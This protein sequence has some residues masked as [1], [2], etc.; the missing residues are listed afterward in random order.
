MSTSVAARPAGSTAVAPSAT[1]TVEDALPSL[2]TAVLA[3]LAPR[4]A[5]RALS[6]DDFR[7]FL[8]FASDV[9]KELALGAEERRALIDAAARVYVSKIAASEIEEALSTSLHFQVAPASRRAALFRLMP[10]KR[11]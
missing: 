11:P 7:E 8:E 6:L 10:L 3:S 9:A 5:P 1:R 4:A 2:A